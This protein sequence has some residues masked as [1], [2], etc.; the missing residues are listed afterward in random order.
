MLHALLSE[1]PLSYHGKLFRVF[2]KQIINI[3]ELKAKDC[4][5]YK[6]LL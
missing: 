5:N 2:I 4:F 6:K 3:L 1:K